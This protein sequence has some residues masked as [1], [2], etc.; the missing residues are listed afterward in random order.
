MDAQ[1]SVTC[2]PKPRPRLAQIIYGTKMMG[3]QAI[4]NKQIVYELLL[5]IYITMDGIECTTCID[6]RGPK[7]S[8]NMYFRMYQLLSTL[9]VRD[10]VVVSRISRVWTV[11]DFGLLRSPPKAGRPTCG[12]SVGC[13]LGMSTSRTPRKVLFFPGDFRQEAPDIMAGVRTETAAAV[14]TT[15]RRSIQHTPAAYGPLKTL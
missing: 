11:R 9:L 6:H 2:T 1:K 10:P 5:L 15:A 13:R 12:F 4:P 8:I 7:L 14:S 3:S